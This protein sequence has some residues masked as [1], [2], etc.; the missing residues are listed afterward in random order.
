MAKH[1]IV[2]VEIPTQNP[3]AT[4]AFYS[5]LFGWKHEYYSNINYHRFYTDEG[6]GGGYVDLGSEFAKEA[7]HKGQQVRISVLTDDI[8]ASLAKAEALGARTVKSR[9]EIP[10]MG[11]FAIFSDPEGNLVGLFSY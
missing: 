1:S 9:T 10:D 6:P 2:H 3:E 8:E 4:N 5:N 7:E 11:A